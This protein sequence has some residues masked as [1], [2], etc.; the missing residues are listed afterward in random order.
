MSTTQRSSRLPR[1]PGPS[2]GYAFLHRAADAVLPAPVFDPPARPGHLGRCGRHAGRAPLFSGTT[3]HRR[4]RGRRHLPASEI[5]GIS[6]RL[7]G[8]SLLKQRLAEGRPHRCTPGPGCLPFLGL[9]ESGRPALL[10]TFHIGHSDMLG[11]LTGQFRRRV[12]M[13]RLKV[14]NSRDTRRL[15]P[16][17]SASGSPSSGSTR[18]K[19]CFSP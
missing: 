9:M 14:E 17:N 7:P 11:F 15:S 16:G 5:G 4:P 13:I 2:W 1:N 3:L 8:R 19:I 12:H 18:R 10:G 6:W